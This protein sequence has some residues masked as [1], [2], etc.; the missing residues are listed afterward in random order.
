MENNM[1]RKTRGL[2]YLV[3]V[4]VVLMLFA[5]ATAT[6]VPSPPH[7][8]Y[9]TVTDQNGNTV[10]DVTVTVSDTDGNSYT[11]TTDTDGYYSL[12]VPAEDGESG[13]T[14]TVAV[15]DA[16]KQT[17]FGS[18]TVERIDF[19]ITVESTT[20]TGDSDD[21]TVSAPSG[22]G[23]AATG[24]GGTTAGTDDGTETIPITITGT[25]PTISVGGNSLSSVGFTSQTALDAT[26][27]IAELTEPPVAGPDGFVFVTAAD[28]TFIRGDSGAIESV[29]LT[30][31]QSRLDELGVSPDQL[32]IYHLNGDT[33]EWKKLD[34]LI[35]E[36]NGNTVTLEAPSDGF[37]VYAVFAEAPDTELTEETTDGA[38]DGTDT[39]TSDSD[40]TESET[41]TEAGGPGF[42]VVVSL[43]AVLV[44]TAIARRRS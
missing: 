22:G 13:E 4:V 29:Q 16:S 10:S 12:E 34:T 30:I 32:A 33:N 20:D 37:S 21:D 28:I 17:T 7:E 36:E 44:A 23:G 40:G 1:T 15:S 27:E 8:A 19:Q 38:E 26:V 9:G 3:V 14:L 39:A 42:T 18:G 35:V 31:P 43:V 2:R 41:M 24:G 5:P 11:T 25:N 6:A